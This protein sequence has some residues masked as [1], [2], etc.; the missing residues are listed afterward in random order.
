M[1]SRVHLG[2]GGSRRRPPPPLPWSAVP[3]GRPARVEGSGCGDGCRVRLKCVSL[4]RVWAYTCLECRR[5]RSSLE[6]LRVIRWKCSR[7]G[8]WSVFQHAKQVLSVDSTAGFRSLRPQVITCRSWISDKG[9]CMPLANRLCD[10]LFLTLSSLRTAAVLR[11]VEF[12]S[13]FVNHE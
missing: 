7:Q 5:Q 4:V 11:M 6:R 1:A 13:K 8:W 12:A 9:F 3:G 10:N 2:Q